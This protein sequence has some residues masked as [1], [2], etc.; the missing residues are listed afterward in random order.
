MTIGEAAALRRKAGNKARTIASA[1]PQAPARG[2][3]WAGTGPE[4]DRPG[5]A[6][7]QHLPG[8]VRA[9]RRT[10]HPQRRDDHPR[11]GSGRRL[12]VRRAAPAPG[13]RAPRTATRSRSARWQSPRATTRSSTWAP[14]RE[15]CPATATTATAFYRS[16]DGG[17]TWTHVS[18]LFTGHVDVRHRRRPDE[19]EPPVPRHGARPR[20]QPPHLRAHQ[21]EVRHL[22]VTDGG[23]TGRCARARPT[24]SHGATDLVMDPQNRKI[25]WASFWGDGIYRSTN[26][27]AH[28]GRT[29]WATCRP[30][31]FLAGGTRFSLGIS[32]P[33]GDTA[34]DALHGLRLHRRR[35][36]YH[37]AR[38]ARPRTAAATG[39]PPPTGVRQRT[40]I[41]DYCGDPV[42]LRQR[43]RSPTRP[44]PTSSTSCGSYGYNQSPQSGGVFRSHA[45]AAS[46]E[47]PRLRPAPRLPRVRL[48][49]RRHQPHRDRQRRRRLAV[50]QPRRSQRRRRPAVRGRLGEPQRH[51]RP[52]HRVR[53]STPRA[54]RSPSS[55]RI[56]T[57]PDRPRAGTGAAPRTTARCASRPANDRWFDQAER[58]RRPGARR[59]DERGLRLRHLLRHLALPLRPSRRPL[60]LR[61]RV[62][63]RR[64]RPERPGR[65]LRPVGA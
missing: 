57:V 54:W 29:R 63:R 36:A 21:R 19:R 4:P 31:N 32:H 64:H 26:G 9:H 24:R 5:R 53:W 52:G 61:Q 23:S 7:V 11:R 18:T 15:R 42:L 1:A 6:D 38:S 14:A 56:A 44:T 17:L 51:G 25:L 49:A 2:G 12:D 33:A 62:H 59:P 16:T 43:D 65:V 46:V 47:E 41:L 48:R 3:A 13:R 37:P 34:A 35:D 45:T 50:A 8:G 20:R 28:A 22:G 60:V 30:G 39:P 58:R 10:G 55:P 40:R 27:G